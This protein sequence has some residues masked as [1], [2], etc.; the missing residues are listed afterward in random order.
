MNKLA[1]GRIV[2]YK[3]SQ[4]DLDILIGL[5]Q[6]DPDCL[7]NNP[8]VGDIVPAIVVR[9]WPDG[10]FNGKA[11]LDGEDLW[12]STVFEGPEPGQFQW[13]EDAVSP[14]KVR[15]SKLFSLGNFENE[16]IDFERSFLV[17]TNPLEALKTL[18][19]EVLASREK[20]IQD[21]RKMGRYLQLQEGIAQNE[22]RL[23]EYPEKLAALKQE[24]E[25]LKKELNIQDELP[26]G[27]PEARSPREQAWNEQAA[28]PT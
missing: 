4:D 17:G 11:F 27:S 23:K 14:I 22:M 8:Q 5:T 2:L 21:E 18:K 7:F 25:A 1:P 16:K 28:E 13:P 10:K 19:T 15:Y 12:I 20:M 26:E 24:A 9:V 3:L 6:K